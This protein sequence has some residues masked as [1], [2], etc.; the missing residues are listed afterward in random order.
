M[1][2]R[3]KSAFHN[4]HPLLLVF[5]SLVVDAED[6]AGAEERGVLVGVGGVVI[7][8]FTPEALGGD[9]DALSED[10]ADHALHHDFVTGDVQRLGLVL[11]LNDDL[12]GPILVFLVVELHAV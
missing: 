5:S 12:L 6:N 2:V 8:L 4:L 1:A 3:T 10:L 11:D 9:A 7:I